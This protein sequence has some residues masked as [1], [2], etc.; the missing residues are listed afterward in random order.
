MIQFDLERVRGFGRLG[1]SNWEMAVVFNCSAKTI[2]R[3]RKQTLLI[4]GSRLKAA[5]LRGCLYSGVRF[6]ERQTLP[7]SELQ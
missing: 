6:D 5:S 3:A 4:A 7:S 2:E 1:A